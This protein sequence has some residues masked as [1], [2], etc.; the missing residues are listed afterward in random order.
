MIFLQ[1]SV[2]H[3][4]FIN[5]VWLLRVPWEE[6]NELGGG[7]GGCSAINVSGPT[8]SHVTPTSI[9]DL[10]QSHVKTAHRNHT[11]VH[12]QRV[13]VCLLT[14]STR[15]CLMLREFFSAE[16]CRRRSLRLSNTNNPNIKNGPG[17]CR[18]TKTWA[19]LVTRAAAHAWTFAL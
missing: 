3:D 15:T 13:T 2:L 10:L 5:P 4:L 1:R 14:N 9:S 17:L 11:R 12:L 8:R 16:R 19:P 7:G 18:Q 6:L